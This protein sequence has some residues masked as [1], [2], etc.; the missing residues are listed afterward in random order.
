MAIHKV[1]A[2]E[3]LSAIAA[4]NNITL[5]ELL[6]AN[7]AITNPNQISVG[8]EI[9]I[10]TTQGSGGGSGSTESTVTEGRLDSVFG[11]AVEQRE[12]PRPNNQ[13]FFFNS[14]T[15]IGVL[16]TT[17]SRSVESSFNSLRDEFSAPHFLIGEGRILQCRPLTAQGSALRGN[18]PCFANAQASIQIEMVGFTGGGNNE[19]TTEDLWIPKDEV[20]LPTVAIMA[21]CAGNGI[22][23]PLR[24]PKE[25][26]KDNASDMPLPWASGT[27]SRRVAAR[28]GDFPSLKGWWMHVEIPCQGPSNHHDCGRLR[29]REMI[30]KAQELLDS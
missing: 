23:I 29:R 7:P 10:P 21:F 17:E 4:Q 2:G 30:A 11:F 13:P 26:W 25:E 28:A 22:D 6:A 3:T 16:H 9:T 8:Q 12:I 27:N 15:Q 14:H 19:S 24:V 1:K 5:S 18:A 20:L